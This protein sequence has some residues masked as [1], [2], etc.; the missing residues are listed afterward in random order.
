M[1]RQLRCGERRWRLQ[2]REKERGREEGERSSRL[3]MGLRRPPRPHLVGLDRHR[4]PSLVRE[5][6]AR[7]Q[8]GVGERE[9]ERGDAEGDVQN[10]FLN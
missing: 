2:E 6:E 8:G 5:F 7:R 4:L 3:S 1:V 10:N 9:R